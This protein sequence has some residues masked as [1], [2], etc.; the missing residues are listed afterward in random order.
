MIVYSR[1]SVI[2]NVGVQS[3]QVNIMTVTED[4]SIHQGST[5]TLE[6]ALSAIDVDLESK[7]RKL[8]FRNDEIFKTLKVKGQEALRN[9]K[10]L[11]DILMFL[12][13]QGKAKH[14]PSWR[15]KPYREN[16]AAQWGAQ[17]Y[18]LV[19]AMQISKEWSRIVDEGWHLDKTYYQVHKLLPTVTPKKVKRTPQTVSSTEDEGVDETE[20]WE[21]STNDLNK[22]IG[23]MVENDEFNFVQDRSVWEVFEE[24]KKM[25]K[26]IAE[27]DLKIQ[28]LEQELAV[29]QVLAIAK[30]SPNIDQHPELF[31]EDD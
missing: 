30:L 20:A 21:S 13:K 10:D 15:W 26:E 8:Y 9:A 24:N 27:K 11:G 1:E 6:V 25:Q 23:F 22:R 5:E 28:E 2:Y 31:K 17:D 12:K 18:R 19:D 29:A 16:L 14:G 3:L 4:L 7:G